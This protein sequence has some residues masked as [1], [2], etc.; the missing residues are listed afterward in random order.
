MGETD[1]TTEGAADF[2][3]GAFPNTVTFTA[4]STNNDTLTITSTPTDVSSLSLH[5]ALPISPSGSTLDGQV[6]YTAG[7]VTIDDADAAT[8]SVDAVTLNE[9]GTAQKVRERTSMQ[10]GESSEN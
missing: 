4:G 6:T 8:V 1:V 9:N 5:D 10:A 2:D 7:T 3:A